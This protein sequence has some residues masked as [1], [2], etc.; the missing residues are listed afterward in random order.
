MLKLLAGLIMAAA[1]LARPVLAQE[2]VA[3]TPQL[4]AAANAEGTLT[5]Q[6]SAPLDAMQ[7]L[8]GDFNK[9]YPKITVELE[10]KAGSSGA[11]VLLQEAAAGVRRI[12][13]FQGT[14]TA[15]NAQ[16]AEQKVFVAL[17]PANVSDFPP[18]ALQMAPYLFFP[19]RYRTVVMY[20]PKFVTSEE[21]AKLSNWRGILDPAFKGR[22][23][24]VEPTF[25]VTL[26]PLLYI[27][28]NKELGEEYLRKLKEQ[29]PIIFVN[30]AQARDAVVSGRAPISWATQWDAVTFSDI[31]RGSPVRFVYTDPVIEF[32]AN[33]WGV[34]A[35]AP[36]PNASRLLFGWLMSRDGAKAME[37]PQYNGRSF[38]KGMDDSRTIMTKLRA[39][40]WFK[41]G[42]TIWSPD[43]KDWVANGPRYQQVW[44]SIMKARR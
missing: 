3:V 35:N 42:T 21:A 31:A 41:S 28:N 10:R 34:I 16:L 33:S 24:L 39:E 30:T 20:N 44:T 14:D 40:P 6:Y 27:M 12:D 29:D 43:I 13:I 23:S 25:G 36:H 32:I 7:A 9:A 18:E 2:V 38:I 19:D 4:V 22:V 15:I 8:I 1:C 26:A 37:G 11:Q 17:Q 5:L